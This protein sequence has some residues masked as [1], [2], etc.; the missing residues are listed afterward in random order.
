MNTDN[1][2]NVAIVLLNWNGWRHTL[3]CLESLF[4]L[5]YPRYTVIVC[6]NNSSDGSM[7]RFRGWA[8]GTQPAGGPRTPELRA[9]AEPV[10]KPIDC[11]V[12]DRP[13]AESSERL[14][15]VP[16]TLIQTGANLG[17]GAGCN[18]GVRHALAQGA[19]FVWLLNTDTLAPSDALRHL[20]AHMDAHPDIALCGST[21]LSLNQPTRVLALGGGRLNRH[22][23]TTTHIG[24]RLSWPLDPA[25]LDAAAAAMDYVVGASMLAR[26]SFVEQAG[27]MDEGY[28]LYYEEL[29]WVQRL[30][31]GMHL[32][33]AP[34]SVVYHVE[35]GTTGGL[36]LSHYYR[37]LMRF[38]WRHNRAHFPRVLARMVLRVPQALFHR[39][40]AK[41]GALV[42]LLL[43]RRIPEG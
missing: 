33:Y 34:A 1:T 37:S 27:L 6:D 7:Q 32:G 26:R 21:L 20:V 28:F 41:L 12:L 23:G 30:P 19:D 14:H 22:T 25:T 8:A 36:L 29:D 31:Q 39:D 3:D 24:D 10:A 5:D 9:L 17:F 42:S 40:W 16:L 15:Q 13:A 35:G 4:R 38:A 43:P 2:P 11:R 18:V